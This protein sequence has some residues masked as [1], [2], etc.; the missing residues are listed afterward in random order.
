M[1]DLAILV[2]RLW[3][4][5]SLGLLALGFGFLCF[6]LILLLWGHE[7]H[8]RQYGSGGWPP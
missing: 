4:T 5:L 3:A 6:E 1:S 2:L 7:G 8:L